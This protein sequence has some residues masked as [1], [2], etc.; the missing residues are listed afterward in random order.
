MPYFDWNATAPLHPAA[1]AAWLEASE[2]AWANP[3]TAYKSGVRARACLDKAREEMAGLLG[4]EPEQVIFTSGATEANNAVIREMTRVAPAR[5]IWISAVEHPSIREPALSLQ[6]GDRVRRIPV[7]KNGRVDLDW[8]ADA[9][10]RTHP[11]VV[12]VMAANNET[13]VI[14]PWQQLQ[15]ICRETG[16]PFHCDA[17]QW[18]GKYAEPI[19]H[20]CAAITLS[21]HK[22]GGPKGIGC[23]IL[24][25]EWTGLKVQSGGAQEMGSRAGTENIPAIAGM[26][27][28]LKARLDS[29]IPEER[30]MARDNFEKALEA[31]WGGEIHIHG[32]AADRLWNTCFVS[33]P[34]HRANRWIAQLDRLGIE[35]SSGSACSASKSGPS[36]ILDAMGVGE[37]SAARTIR[38][39]SGWETTPA[40][41]N[42]LFEALR[43]ARLMLDSEPAS[44]GPGQ[45][46]E[47]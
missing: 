47:I 25:K 8:V 44:S 19:G 46:I 23:L 16:V 36:S 27:A 14:Q 11:V 38:I 42:E 17:V 18:I 37:A 41:W 6:D 34:D 1:H 28:A 40:D 9:L 31:E 12:S 7:D 3:S 4:F 45:V 20:E 22:F 33:L 29:P 5:E 15:G 35:V 10:K 43:Q 39:S 26:V 24:G 32:K 30:L 21:G 2:T 13:G